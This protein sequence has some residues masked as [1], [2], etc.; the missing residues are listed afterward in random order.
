MAGFEVTFYGRIWVTPK[1]MIVDCLFCGG[2]K[3]DAFVHGWI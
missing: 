2:G 3:R 1:A